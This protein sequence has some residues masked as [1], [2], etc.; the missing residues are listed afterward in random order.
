MAKMH[1]VNRF[2]L[3]VYLIDYIKILHSLGKWKINKLLPL[4]PYPF[5]K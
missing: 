1:Y 3:K 4:G 5:D 2:P